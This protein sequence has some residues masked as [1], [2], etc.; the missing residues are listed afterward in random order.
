MRPCGCSEDQSTLCPLGETLSS[1]S[2]SAFQK[3]IALVRV[4]DSGVG[5]CRNS[6]EKAH[7]IFSKR[8]SEFLAHIA[9]E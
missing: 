1:Q 3:Y 9:G 5:V 8:R 7:D 4:N 6:M 2:D